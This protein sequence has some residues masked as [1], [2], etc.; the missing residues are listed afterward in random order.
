M[1]TV[2]AQRISLSPLTDAANCSNFSLKVKPKLI[3]QLKAYAG[4]RK[5]LPTGKHKRLYL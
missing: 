4:E 2:L 1:Y 3:R 5:C